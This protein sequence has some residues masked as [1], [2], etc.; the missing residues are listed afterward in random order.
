MN[1]RLKLFPSIDSLLSQAALQPWLARLQRPIV[2]NIA[3]AV[4]SQLKQEVL[5]GSVDGLES[6]KAILELLLKRVEERLRQE[7]LPSL[8]PVINATGVILHTGLGR[9]PLPPAAQEALGRIMI[10]YCNLEFDLETGERGERT[11]HVRRLLCELTGAEDA[12]MVNNN[13]AAVFLALNTLA[14]GKEAIVSRGQLIEIGGS[15]RLPEIMMRS[16][17]IMREVGTTNRTRLRDYEAAI[18]PNTALIVVAHPSNYRVMGFTEEADLKELCRLAH[19]HNLP[20]LYDLGAGVLVDFRQYGLPY[21]PMVQE[22]LEA[23]ADIVTFSGDKV[24]GGPQAGLIVGKKIFLQ[25]MHRNPIMRAVRCD[26]MTY[27]A[28]EATL[29]LFQRT[30]L[31]EQHTV[32]R[33]LLQSTDEL[34]KRAERILQRFPPELYHHLQITVEPRPAQFGSGALPLETLPSAALVLEP[35]EIKVTELARRLRLGEPAVIGYIDKN[36]LYLDLRS[37]FDEQTDALASAV[38]AAVLPSSANSQADEPLTQ[39]HEK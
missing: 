22:S 4:V 8:R 24:I 31:I 20:L 37:V 36:R 19:A 6:R 27:A 21:E 26:K 9:A 14:A 35:L 23:G 2:R 17:A 5:A 33:L 39:G 13:A 3:A 12:L 30:D 11:D 7:E 18:G 10:G 34:Q 29:R 38:A 28:M 25:A 15:F 16:G 1:E 32:L